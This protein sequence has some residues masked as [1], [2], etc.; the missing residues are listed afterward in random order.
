MEKTKGRPERKIGETFVLHGYR[1]KKAGDSWKI[2][3]GIQKMDYVI[4]EN[5][6]ID[7]N[8]R[9]FDAQILDIKRENNK[10]IF[11]VRL[12]PHK[13]SFQ[14]KDSYGHE[15]ILCKNVEAHQ[16]KNNTYLLYDNNYHKKIEKCLVC[17]A[18]RIEIE[19]HTPD[20]TKTKCLCG[21]T[22]NFI[23]DLNKIKS[24]EMKLKNCLEKNNLNQ[25]NLLD[26]I[27]EFS[28][29]LSLST[30]LE[31]PQR[32][33]P[34]RGQE[35]DLFSPLKDVTSYAELLTKSYKNIL[36]N[37]NALKICSKIINNYNRVKTN[38]LQ[39]IYKIDKIL[40]ELETYFDDFEKSD[41]KTFLTFNAGI[42]NTDL[43][44]DEIVEHLN[45]IY[46]LPEIIPYFDKFHVNPN[47]RTVFILL[48]TLFYKAYIEDD[49]KVK[50]VGN[51]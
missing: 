1:L 39:A 32:Y 46:N 5:S 11:T 21:F 20:E 48:I 31:E 24:G 27:L 30:I 12:S 18:E 29:Y 47:Y 35:Y 49:T 41:L 36:E 26:K 9:S 37:N 51:L 6:I 50:Q 10:K 43:S 8:D 4:D 40:N 34:E 3:S 45:K 15:C 44:Y 14:K 25:K 2:V 33:L 28:F 7:N 17:G 38:Y 13:Y 23:K 19:K 22:P 16:F 42:L